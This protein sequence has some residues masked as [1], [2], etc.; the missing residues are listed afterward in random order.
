M[1]F[2]NVATRFTTDL[3]TAMSTDPDVYAERLA[4]A[5]AKGWE[6]FAG[7]IVLCKLL[8]YSTMRV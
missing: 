3:D 2:G 8:Q 6:R 1:R 4:A 5:L 7:R